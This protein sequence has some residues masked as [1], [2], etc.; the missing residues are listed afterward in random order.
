MTFKTVLTLGR[1]SNLPTVW[2][3][4]IA[5]AVLAGQPS[6]AVIV[7][8]GLA[9]SLFY[10]GGMWLNDAF[11]AEIDARE[12]ANRPIP[13]GEIAVGTVFAV[14]FAL[15]GAGIVLAFTL[16]VLAGVAGIALA[17]AVVLYDWLH[18]RTALSPVIMGATR[19]FCY[20]L[21]A[22]AVGSIGGPVVFGAL[23][24][25]AYIVGLTYAAKQE[26]YDRLDRAWPLAVLAVPLLYGLVQAMPGA[27]ALSI[28]AGLLA[29]V[30]A[31]LR[32]LFR[33]RRGDVPRAVVTMIAG[34]SLYD[35]V[36]IAAAGQAGLAL[37]AV[38]GFALTL[39][40]QRVVSGT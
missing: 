24:L 6:V 7:T 14:G 18:K 3:N 4:A 32:L 34:I 20:V 23:G 19:F 21:P 22:A 1:V 9:L 37:L 2:T 35:A 29:V 12:R 27:L 17:A 33:R 15:L 13:R 38:V 25:L 31:A 26:A 40:L 10:I 5:G 39:V 11:D 16:G 30:L 8:S 28:W 36:L